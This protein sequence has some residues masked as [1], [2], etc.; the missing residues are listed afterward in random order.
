VVTYTAIEKP[1]RKLL[2]SPLAIRLLG[3]LL[4]T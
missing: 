4:Q 2:R 3:T 1:C